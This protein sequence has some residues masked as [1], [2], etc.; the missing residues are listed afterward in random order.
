MATPRQVRW[1]T[2]LSEFDFS[3]KYTPGSTNLVADGLSRAAA[4]GA[5]AA[6]DKANSGQRLL[7]NAVTEM[8]PIPVRVRRAATQDQAYQ[9]MLGRD[10]A[11]L[12]ASKLS[13]TKGLLYRQTPDGAVHGGH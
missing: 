2:W 8:A 9:E 13:K 4:G 12:E 5:R 6:G 10:D 1:A 3:I 7:I 11:H